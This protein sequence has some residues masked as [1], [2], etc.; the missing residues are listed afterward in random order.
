MKR[1]GEKIIG[2]IWGVIASLAVFDCFCSFNIGFWLWFVILL[3]GSFIT[4]G[5]ET[6]LFVANCKDVA[7]MSL[8]VGQKMYGIVKKY[9]KEKINE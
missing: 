6:Y 7:S 5:L 8:K 4:I 1:F 3:V 9:H 2:F